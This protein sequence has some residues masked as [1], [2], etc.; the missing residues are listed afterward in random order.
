MNQQTKIKDLASNGHSISDL[1]NQHQG[2]KLAARNV[3]DLFG[4]ASSIH[5]AEDILAAHFKALEA[6]SS[7]EQQ[8]QQLMGCLADE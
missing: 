8:V 1:L 4:E 5:N 6:A 3:L 7:L 2:A